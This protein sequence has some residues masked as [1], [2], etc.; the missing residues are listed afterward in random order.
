MPMS[1]KD[2]TDTSSARSS[3][4][5]YLVHKTTVVYTKKDGKDK[6]SFPALEWLAIPCSRIPNKGE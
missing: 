6:K 5:T 2:V 4:R 3:H 1:A